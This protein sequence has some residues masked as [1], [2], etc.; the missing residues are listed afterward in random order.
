M[1]PASETPEPQQEA[2]AV[3]GMSCLFPRSP[4]LEAYWRLLYHGLDGIGDVP[5][6]HWSIE[7]YFSEDPS[8]KDRVYVKR[9]GFLSPVDFD[10]MAFGI[11]PNLLEATDTSQLLGLV[12]ARDCLQDAGYPAE[13][14]DFDRDRV[15]VILGVT[16]T[17][18][19]VIPLGARLGHPHWRR[20][21]A[22]AG[23][24]GDK[25]REIMDRIAD[26]YV[27]W[28]EGSF[29]GLLGNV[30][31]GRICNRLDL[32]GT[33]CVV[34]AACASSMSALHLALL[35][36]LS[37]RSDMVVTGGVDTLN[38]IFMHMCFASTQ[39]LSPT[40]DVRPFSRKADGTLL[41]EGIGML[42]LKRLSD[43]EKDGDRIYA[44]IRG[45]GTS[46]DGRSQSIYAPR[47]AGQAKALRQAYRSAGVTP[48]TVTLV[49][50][51]GT[52]TR[53]GDRTEVE[54]LRE[55]FGGGDRER[56]FCAL[57][58]VKS[59]IGHTKAAAG[60]AGLI[61]AVLALHH[62]VLPATIKAED[63][64]PGLH[65]EDSPFYLNHRSRPWFGHPDHPRRAGVSAFGFGGSNFH[66]VVEEYRP[67]KT[68][69][70][71]DPAVEIAALSGDTREALHEA[72]D[73]WRSFFEND[74][75]AD[76][77]ARRA[78]S[79]REA[80]S[81]SDEQR[82]LVVL[83]DALQDP[84]KTAALFARAA[85][86]LEER[87]DQRRWN[88]GNVFFGSGP[89][90]GRL[91]FMF[92][93]QGS[94]YV[95]MGSD[96]ACTFPEA[97]SLF[98]EANR[99]C[100]LP[101][102]LSDYVY[103]PPATDKKTLQRQEAD[104]R[105]TDIA[106]PAIGAVSLMMDRVLAAFG[107]R[108]EITCGHS[109]GELCAHFA[110][111]WI[112]LEALFHLSVMRGRY[113]AAAGRSGGEAGGMLAVK[114]PLD[115]LQQLVETSGLDLI[116]ANRNSP[117][118]GVLSGTLEA[119]DRAAA[120]C[121]QQGFR[122]IK[123]P[124][125][126]AFHSRLVE[127][128]QRPFARELEKVRFSPG[129]IGVYSNTTAGPYPE[130]AAEAREILAGQ[131]LQPVDF[132]NEIR[133]I[134]QSGA[135]TFVE[136]GPRV[137]LTGLVKAILKGED[138]H[139]F[140]VDA[141]SG[142]KSGLA[143][144]ARCL[145]QLAALGHGV[146]L[147]RWGGP[148]PPAPR[149]KPVMNIPISGANYRKPA[150]GASGTGSRDAADPEPVSAERTAAPARPA[151][152]AAPTEPAPARIPPDDPPTAESPPAPASHPTPDGSLAAS[153]LQAV[154]QGLSA[155]ERLQQETAR[156][157]Q[158]FLES[159]REATV[160]LQRMMAQ[161]ALGFPE[162]E[163]PPATVSPLP[164]MSESLSPAVPSPAAP[165]VEAFQPPTAPA[166]GAITAAPAQAPTPAVETPP[167]RSAAS[168][169]PV[170]DTPAASSGAPN[171]PAPHNAPPMEKVLLEVVAELTGY[172]AEMLRLDMDIEADLGIDSIKRVEILSAFEEKL[173][174]LPPISPDK[175]ATLK[176]L[177]QIVDLLTETGDMPSAPPADPAPPATDTP[178]TRP[179]SVPAAA[180]AIEKVL[181]E[182]VAELTGYPAEMLRLDMDIEADLGIDSIKRVE[183]LS[184]FE[185]KLPDLPPISPDKVATL[186]TL[187][188][189]VAV[190]APR[191]AETEPAA[192]PP[193]PDS[194]LVVFPGRKTDDAAP[195]PA[196]G[197]PDGIQ[198]RC[199]RFR[200]ASFQPGASLSLAPGRRVFIAGA[201]DDPLAQALK[202]RLQS[203]GVASEVLSLARAADPAFTPTR[204]AGLVL[205]APED[206]PREGEALYRSDFAA[207]AFAALHRFA[208]HLADAAREG[209]A[210]LATVSRLDGR[211]GF[212]GEAQGSPLGAALAGMTKTASHEWPSVTCRA[213][214]VPAAGGGESATAD[215][216]AAELLTPMDTD[217][218]EIGLLPSGGAIRRMVPVLADEPLPVQDEE[219]LALSAGEVVVVSGGARGITAAA[220]RALADAVRP[221]L[222]ILG[223]S[224][225][226]FE[227][228]AWLKN[229][230]EPAEIKKAVFENE[231]AGRA[232]PAEVEAAYRRYR[233][234]RELAAALKAV[235][236]AG[237]PVFY[238]SVDIRD[239]L[240]VARIINGVRQQHG[241]V[242]A[243]I[244]AA[245]VLEDRFIADKTPEQFR[246]V[247]DTKVGGLG[248]LLE[249][250]DPRQLRYLVLFSSVAARMGNPGQ[251]DYAAANEV[252][253][254]IAQQDARRLPDCRCLSINWG[255]WDGGMVTS[256]LKRAFADR[257]IDLI[258]VET[259][260]RCLLLEMS[261]PP[262]GD[263]EVV[264]GARL[265]SDEKQTAAPAAP[266]GPR[267]SL[268]FK[269]KVSTRTT[270][271]LE[272]HV[273]DGSPVVPLALMTEWMA[274]GA[275]HENP[276][277]L[278]C[279]LQD[280]RLLKGIR[281][282]GGEE[283][284]VRLMAGKARPQDALYEVPVE[285]RD[286]IVDGREDI[287]ARGSVLLSERLPQA[288]PDFDL[289]AYP[290][291]QSYG[292]STREIYGQIL[293]HGRP[294][295]GIRRVAAGT[296]KF[297][298]AR[299]AAAPPP[300]RWMSNPL[301]SR[302]IMDP[303]VLDCAFQM[304]ILWCYDHEGMV[305]LPSYI[306][307]YTQYRRR[308]PAD[309]VTAVL[310]SVSTSGRRFTGD[311]TFVDADG[312]VVARMEGYEAVMSP[313]LFN[314]FRANTAA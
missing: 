224:P 275:L 228:P 52:G 128:A 242:R 297:M 55:V 81:R 291:G 107:V 98:E 76:E 6:S 229:A 16:G 247:F 15:S 208:P 221:T 264:V 24:E 286:G 63:P 75:S 37:G 302:W 123:L 271:I 68:H 194:K 236:E 166:P 21:L 287:H 189:I 135:A 115:D 72:L 193:K 197:W 234:N 254:K 233:A 252:L 1:K 272:A 34:D 241:P 38:D 216:V 183:I 293:F 71:W 196:A 184:A 79:S 306:R 300:A 304:A 266:A 150:P 43:A 204:A 59:M 121:K 12:V 167:A 240:A 225:A 290:A 278:L 211:F 119:I 103:P 207:E 26:S 263:V 87:A 237:A 149:K 277:L 54:A 25:A 64:D 104:L 13:R 65:L 311:F 8:A 283:K 78:A 239:R 73:A 94:Q 139:C 117:S 140:G 2:V 160:A 259:G 61:K 179:S 95:G 248:S 36:L 274:H 145:G 23:I 32:G 136:V 29:P 126:A 18:E 90:P 92:P 147:N 255:P 173:P 157:H 20:A 47:A 195:L 3:I 210:V 66:A 86:T 69:T 131:I 165:P 93:G 58:S 141:S 172:P 134:F 171:R 110:A 265:V 202:D 82:L 213:F 215:A 299:V 41:G 162:G 181:L 74:P 282:V 99:R 281:L 48:D 106:Q 307:T 220:T 138:I 257:G 27:S 313:T 85:D 108:P 199:V 198:R 28:Q 235:E 314:A 7:D 144:L 168:D 35:E 185:E 97:L 46:S 256:S 84:Q 80:F 114:A 83:E 60:S 125:A 253:N 39:I 212:G 175:V 124:V 186:K 45:L 238:H 169:A 91:V 218:V 118:Q 31:A 206:L 53:V 244:H 309:G 122:A 67:A 188:Q 209:D 156:T 251:A 153:A 109:Y 170:V 246:R 292:R 51:H 142:K 222:L 289:Q 227:E 158:L 192:E 279:G 22:S 112:D 226:V 232:A 200:E 261:R 33:N 154:R 49:E 163:A 50:A 102:R 267:L 249:A 280:V 180:P 268:A 273:I 57:G 174:D 284:V 143:D 151:P 130:D 260:V 245:G 243:V 96:L 190:I 62:K 276:G 269:Q 258:P 129:E 214:D 201:E 132:V 152:T 56:P 105:S 205:I 203:R 88:F 4:G 223:R 137:V 187:G 5:E 231:F 14:E 217:G 288:P 176:T 178:T 294:L 310:E 44:V 113:M 77:L 303:L 164:G 182:V 120:L 155:I 308:F 295:Q 262:G 116:L 133:H 250:V 42:A 305:S 296:R 298:A 9:G 70:S 101:R 159:Q 146:N 177:G 111:G 100:R 301:R 11:P 312:A 191:S 148:P 161:T 127:D 30:V 219:R 89:R 285:V 270:G 17:Q 10:P 230:V 40:G 19:L